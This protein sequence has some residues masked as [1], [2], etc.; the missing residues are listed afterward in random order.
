MSH[1]CYAR[2][3]RF[4]RSTAEWESNTTP[5]GRMVV[6]DGGPDLLLANCVHGCG[7]TLGREVEA[8]A[9]RGD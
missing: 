7:S 2:H 1:P 4:K 6:G 3:P 5:V 8:E 9:T